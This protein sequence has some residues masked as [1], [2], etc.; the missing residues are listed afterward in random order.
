MSALTTNWYTRHALLLFKCNYKFVI[1]HGQTVIVLYQ[2]LVFKVYFFACVFKDKLFGLYALILLFLGIQFHVYFFGTFLY[3]LSTSY[4]Q[5]VFFSW[6]TSSVSLV[7]LCFKHPIRSIRPRSAKKGLLAASCP[8]C[9]H[10][11]SQYFTEKFFFLRIFSSLGR[12][13]VYEFSLSQDLKDLLFVT[14]VYNF[15][16]HCF[17]FAKVIL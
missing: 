9:L 10:F 17:Q 8:C 4:C 14:R 16:H 12:F 7:S 13:F 2:I 11:L 15:L 6:V 1:L 5:K 3:C